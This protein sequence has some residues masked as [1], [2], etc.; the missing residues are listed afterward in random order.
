MAAGLSRFVITQNKLGGDKAR[1][2][3]SVT[4]SHDESLSAKVSIVI[5]FHTSR[6]IIAVRDL[7]DH[8]TLLIIAIAIII[9]LGN[10]PHEVHPRAAKFNRVRHRIVCSSDDCSVANESLRSIVNVSS[11]V[12]TPERPSLRPRNR[13]SLRARLFAALQYNAS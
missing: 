2:L 10:V 11:A 13:V 8:S 9:Y 1:I 7:V 3:Q 12:I 6:I 5:I 4:S